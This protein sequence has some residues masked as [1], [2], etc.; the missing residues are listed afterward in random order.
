MTL[1]QA[2]LSYTIAWA[3][4]FFIFGFI[5]EETEWGY[6]LLKFW[7]SNCP[8]CTPTGLPRL[9]G[10]LLIVCHVLEF[11]NIIGRSNPY[12]VLAHPIL[13]VV[14]L[15]VHRRSKGGANTEAM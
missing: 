4:L 12:E 1:W 15:D 5:V 7:N 13:F 8:V 3:I 2:V 14:S 10:V 6:R 9:T 11:K